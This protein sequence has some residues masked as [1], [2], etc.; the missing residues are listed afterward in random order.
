MSDLIRVF[1]QSVHDSLAELRRIAKAAKSKDDPNLRWATKDELALAEQ[2]HSPKACTG[3]SSRTGLPCNN[4][5]LK[6]MP[7]CRKHGGA[8]K[9]S[10]LAI[11]RRLAEVAPQRLE[12]MITLAEDTANEPAIAFKANQD[13]LDRFGVGALVQAKVRASKKQ[14]HS[15]PSVTVNIGFL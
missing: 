6:G 13:L 3:H 14:E 7:V 9:A 4:P 2:Q 11:K 5:P 8:T 12:S 1:P 15:G 10:R